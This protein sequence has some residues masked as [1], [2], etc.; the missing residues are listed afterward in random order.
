MGMCFTFAGLELLIGNPI[1][2]AISN[3][4][5]GKFKGAQAYSAATL[6]ARTAGSVAVR[7]LLARS[8]DRG[9]KS[10]KI[11]RC[12]SYRKK[13]QRHC[14]FRKALDGK[15]GIKIETLSTELFEM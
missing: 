1:A 5:E 4:P 15:E 6:R 14:F 11:Q 9:G 10:W 7:M 3:I 8:G 2:G 13:S 12:F